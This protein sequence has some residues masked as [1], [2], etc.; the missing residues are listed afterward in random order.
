MLATRRP[1]PEEMH[2]RKGVK[3]LGEEFVTWAGN[4]LRVLIYMY[5]K[6]HLAGRVAGSSWE[7]GVRVNAFFLVHTVHHTAGSTTYCLA[8]SLDRWFS[9]FG[10]DLTGGYS[11]YI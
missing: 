10:G 4:L 7:L 6:G 3:K 2:S 9:L 11:L 5:V 8:L 1:E